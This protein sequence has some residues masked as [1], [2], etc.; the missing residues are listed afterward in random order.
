MALNPQNLL[1]ANPPDLT[2]ALNPS[3]IIALMIELRFQ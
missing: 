3:E 2:E 1:P